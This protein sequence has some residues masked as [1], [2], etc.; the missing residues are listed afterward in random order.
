MRKLAFCFVL[1]C[2]SAFLA[3]SQGEAQKHFEN[4]VSKVKT[5]KSIEM[6]LDAVKDFNKAIG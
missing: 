4:G 3:Y 1:V 5:K 2:I 6:L